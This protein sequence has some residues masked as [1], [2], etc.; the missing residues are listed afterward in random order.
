MFQSLLK[1]LL[2][3]RIRQIDTVKIIKT[4]LSSYL[5]GYEGM[6]LFDVY[7]GDKSITALF[8]TGAEVSLVHSEVLKGLNVS[9]KQVRIS[10]H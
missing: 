9:Y 4:L 10:V 2:V 6:L 8:D 5:W 3:C 7:F 1:L